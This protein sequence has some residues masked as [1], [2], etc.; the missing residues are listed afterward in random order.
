MKELTL[1]ASTANLPRVL[2][3]IET[4]LEDALCP[5]KA[6][7]QTGVAAEEI[8][9][10]IASY[11]YAPGT[12]SATVRVEISGSPRTAV[13]TFIDSGVPY[14][15]LAKPDPDVTLSAKERQIGGLGIFMTKK[16]MDEV[17]YEYKDGHNVLTLR[18]L[19]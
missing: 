11:A 12:G 17:A 8:F 1:E 3:F 16:L 7:M 15:P 10:N 14:D 19:L 9:V 4:E 13:I 18:K 2:D 5:M 6:R